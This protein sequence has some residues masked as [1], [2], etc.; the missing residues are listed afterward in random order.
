M[1]KIFLVIALLILITSGSYGEEIAPP[2]KHLSPELE[3]YLDPIMRQEMQQRHTPGAVVV[4]VLNGEIVLQKGYG[5]AD[6]DQRT[7]VK[8]NRTQFR[9]GSISKLFTTTAIL[10]LAEEGKLNLHDDVN[11]YLKTFQIKNPFPEPVRVFHLLT[12]TAGFD[13]RNLGSAT[14]KASE[15]QS[16]AQYLPGN[17]PPCVR[18][19][20]SLISYSNHGFTLAGYLV[21]LVSGM[22]FDQYVEEH[23]LKP[24]GMH[25]STINVKESRSPELATGYLFE[26]KDYEAVPFDYVND[27]P[28]DGLVS[29]APDMA[30]FMLANLQQ[31][32]YGN[33]QILRPETLAEMQAQH[34]THH[35]DMPGWCYGYYEEYRNNLRG[36]VHDGTVYGFTSRVYLVPEKQFGFFVASNRDTT[37]GALLAPALTNTLL[38]FYFPER[39]KH[40]HPED[41][42]PEFTR[43]AHLCEGYYRLTCYANTTLEKIE[44][45]MGFAPEIKVVLNPD[46]TLMI[47]DKD[48]VEIEPFYFEHTNGNSFASFRQNADGVVT[49]VFL[50][51]DAFERLQWYETNRFQ[52]TFAGSCLAVFIFTC[53]LC[54]IRALRRKRKPEI[55]RLYLLSGITSAAHLIFVPVLIQTIARRHLFELSYAV[56]FLLKAA[57]LLPI[58]ALILAPFLWISL[59]KSWKQHAGALF[60]RMYFCIMAIAATGFLWILNY[61]NLIGF[62]Y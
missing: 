50:E 13:E 3:A 47:A 31:G 18:P 37:S 35:P 46:N 14:L 45:L 55:G 62:R 9:M 44:V 30:R 61:W 39:K 22:P 17:M 1:N 16:L 4:V 60:E 26:N 54:L 36:L 6:R 52:L 59:V 33:T 32:R 34:F 2:P 12:H 20:G 15:A 29:T 53:F 10:Q 38:D 51:Q 24:L 43:R 19:P 21:E 42:T 48:Y 58:L 8:A 23:I 49:N 56:P 40:I 5:F 11:K 27:G 25:S 7:P 57:L 41:A 28:A